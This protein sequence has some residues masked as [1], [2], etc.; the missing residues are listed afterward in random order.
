M[1]RFAASF[2]L[3]VCLLFSQTLEA[4]VRH[5]IDFPDLP[6][7]LTLK[8]DFHMH[9]V[10]SDG[11]VWPTVRVD[12]AWRL[13]LDAISLTDHI[14]YQPHRDDIPSDP[15]RSYEL[16][17]GR[18]RERNLLF[19]RAT[20]I[21]RD[22]PPGHFN[23]L[24]LDDVRPLD[25]P[26]FLDAIENANK[27]NA[28][29]FWNHHDWKGPERGRWLAA[30]ALLYNN[31][32]LHGM[33]VCNGETY[34]PSAHRWCLDKGLTMVGNSDIHEPDRNEQSTADNHR[35]LTLVFVKER[36]LDGLKE[37]LFDG[38]TVVWFEDQLIGKRQWLEPLFG[39]C[40]SVEAPHH[41][42]RD[43]LW[44]QVKNHSPVEFRLQRAGDV[45]P[46]EIVLPANAVTLLK[47]GT[48]TPEAVHELTYTAT[49]LLMEP[50][51]GLP[52]TLRI[53]ATPG[54]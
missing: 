51:T 21:T 35:T 24:F 8:C 53:P 23:A 42:T 39:G 48:K 29:V 27:Q 45:G 44:T 19:P 17:A 38:R 6:E 52:V 43:A 14:E 12:E 41:R 11:Q 37:A 26:E 46:K 10:F 47:I 7:H 20:E 25:T 40:V 3:L 36:T 32:W 16:A 15:N 28:F 54:L 33:E 4:Q 22:T 9:T 50:E 49:N 31:K 1:I 13:G 18:A 30:H 34:Y 2:S 5:E